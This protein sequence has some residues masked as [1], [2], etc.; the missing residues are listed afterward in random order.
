MF[1][2]LSLII[3]LLTSVHAKTITE[4]YSIEFGI[5]GEIA[6]VHANMEIDKNHYQIDSKLKVIGLIANKVTKNL[7]E[8]HISK[9][10]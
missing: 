4:N 1:R 7:K 10:H 2:M 8:R 3:F 9:G 5:I 6:K